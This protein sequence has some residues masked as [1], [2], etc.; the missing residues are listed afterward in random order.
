MILG[1]APVTLTEF[2]LGRL[3]V[4]DDSR[5]LVNFHHPGA[6]PGRVEPG[7]ARVE[8]LTASIINKV[9]SSVRRKLQS[10]E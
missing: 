9:L 2:V 5:D 8:E 10:L 1:A 7:N 3:D 6:L 4:V